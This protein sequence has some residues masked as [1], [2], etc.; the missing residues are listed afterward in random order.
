[1]KWE[2]RFVKRDRHRNENTELM[3]KKF[4]KNNNTTHVNAQRNK[5]CT[6]L[7]QHTKTDGCRKKN[8]NVIY[9]CNQWNQTKRNGNNGTEYNTNNKWKQQHHTGYSGLYIV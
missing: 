9:C 7:G 8:W 2:T 5:K 3:K 4:N 6:A 1:M